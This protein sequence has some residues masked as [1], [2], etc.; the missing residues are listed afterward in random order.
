MPYN[1]QNKYPQ[2]NR[3]SND[4][5]IYSVYPPGVPEYNPTAELGDLI[6]RRDQPRLETGRIDNPLHTPE[7]SRIPAPQISG[8]LP[9]AAPSR[10]IPSNR[11]D[12]SWGSQGIQDDIHRRLLGNTSY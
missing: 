5:G 1:P 6:S 2:N 3:R 7:F 11:G 9:V 8:T 4:D 12:L 10:P